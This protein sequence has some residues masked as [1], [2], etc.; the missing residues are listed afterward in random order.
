MNFKN[1]LLLVVV[2]TSVI[3]F[4]QANLCLPFKSDD[5]G[6]VTRKMSKI[7][8]LLKANY[9]NRMHFMNLGKRTKHKYY[10]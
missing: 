5:N 1:D 10:Y 7:E 4:F 2:V 9:K 6:K 8:A 3:L